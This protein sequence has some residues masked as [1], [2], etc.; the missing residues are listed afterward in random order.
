MHLMQTPNA[1]HEE[2]MTGGTF[3]E[4]E[5]LVATGPPPPLEGYDP[6]GVGYQ[7]TGPIYLMVA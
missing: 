1:P 2:Y 6:H 5:Q 4:G 7:A 3:Q